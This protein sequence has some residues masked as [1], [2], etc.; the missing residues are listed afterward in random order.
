LRQRHLHRL[1][2]FWGEHE[3]LQHLKSLLD[4]VFPLCHR[5]RPYGPFHMVSR[6]SGARCLFNWCGRLGRSW[7]LGWQQ[8]DSEE[9]R[10]DQHGHSKAA[11]WVH[12]S[13]LCAS[14][15]LCTC[16]AWITTSMIGTPSP[17]GEGAACVPALPHSARRSKLPTRCRGR[18]TCQMLGDQLLGFSEAP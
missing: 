11:I 14:H 5:L 17:T 12:S 13:N 3:V 16:L 4:G 18:K 8:T 1:R 9:Q 7:S 10:H 15:G 2:F 6:C